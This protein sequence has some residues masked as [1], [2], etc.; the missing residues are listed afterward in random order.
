MAK[1]IN[2]DQIN[3][4]LRNMLKLERRRA[5]GACQKGAQRTPFPIQMNKK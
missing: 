1:K 4:V 2:P 5:L 3:D